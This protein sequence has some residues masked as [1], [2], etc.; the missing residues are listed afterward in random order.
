[1]SFSEGTRHCIVCKT[2]KRANLVNNLKLTGSL[3]TNGCGNGTDDFISK[4][5][6]LL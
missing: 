5:T 6:T 2:P 4:D 1:M 3:V